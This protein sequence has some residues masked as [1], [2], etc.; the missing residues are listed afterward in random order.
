[1][2]TD[3][4]ELL[5]IKKK[6]IIHSWPDN[7]QILR[8]RNE[9]RTLVKFIPAT[10]QQLDQNRST[11]FKLSFDRSYPYVVPNETPKYFII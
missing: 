1:M 8:W 2:Y 10:F 11:W 7:W 5:E 6:Q 9:K 3:R 4:E